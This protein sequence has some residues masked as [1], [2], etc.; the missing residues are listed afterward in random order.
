MLSPSPPEK[1]TWVA[2]PVPCRA[3]V[4]LDSQTGV[5]LSM[6]LT[7]AGW[8]LNVRATAVDLGPDPSW[9]QPD[10]PMEPSEP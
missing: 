5:M 10:G 3:T 2:K 6:T 1:S 8:Q 4:C 9:Y 7:A